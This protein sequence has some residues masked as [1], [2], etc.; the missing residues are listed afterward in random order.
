MV[1]CAEAGIPP[2]TR[3]WQTGTSWQALS[4]PIAAG[5][6]GRR[7]AF[8]GLATR[9]YSG[10]Q[11]EGRGVVG[12]S[13]TSASR[14]LYSSREAEV[15]NASNSALAMPSKS[16]LPL[17]MPDKTPANDA[18]KPSQLDSL[19]KQVGF[20]KTIVS[21]LIALIVVA[22]SA[23]V[24][25]AGFKAYEGKVDKLADDLTRLTT[26]ITQFKTNIGQLFDPSYVIEVTNDPDGSRCELGNVVNGVKYDE[27]HHRMWIRCASISRTV[28]NPSPGGYLNPSGQQHSQKKE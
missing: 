5:G 27:E 3:W 25:W 17:T 18:S 10:H 11:V 16:V 19:E 7:P 28:W 21:G 4:R 13:P 24:L 1:K 15:G 9:P 8:T 2:S 26:D 6:G 12:G 20:L 23:G 14:Q 22:F